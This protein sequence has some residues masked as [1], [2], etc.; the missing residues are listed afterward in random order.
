MARAK[1]FLIVRQQKSTGSEV[2]GEVRLVVLDQELDVPHLFLVLLVTLGGEFLALHLEVAG[3]IRHLLYG[4]VVRNGGGLGQQFVA[5]VE[6]AA[7]NRLE[8]FALQFLNV[9]HLL[10]FGAASNGSENE[11]QRDQQHP[12][13][14]YKLHWT[15]PWW[16]VEGK[17]RPTA[18]IRATTPDQHIISHFRGGQSMTNPNLIN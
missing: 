8:R 4:R 7:T 17:I 5:A 14:Q 13:S 1:D 12:T 10:R 3:P 2:D 15:H 18:L 9:G 11:R 16:R 6:M